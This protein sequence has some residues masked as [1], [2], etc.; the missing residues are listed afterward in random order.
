[1]PIDSMLRDEPNG[2]QRLFC[3][4][5]CTCRPAWDLDPTSAWKID[6]RALA[7][8]RPFRD[9]RRQGGV[10]ALGVARSRDTG[11]LTAFFAGQVDSRLL[12]RQLS[13]PVPTMSQW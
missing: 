6:L 3:A 13:L 12:N 2:R 1:M 8:P 10:A 7:L 5:K 4:G 11:M 9:R